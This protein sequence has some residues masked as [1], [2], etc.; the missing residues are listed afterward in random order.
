[1]RIAYLGQMA[2]VA[3][4]NGISKKIR[5]QAAAWLEAGHAVRYFALT[6]SATLWSGLRP[7]EAEVLARGGPLTRTVQSHRLARR[8]RA[9]RPDVIYFRYA[10]HSPGLPALF[11]EIPCV[12][13]INSD[14]EREYPLT[15]TPLKLAYHRLSRARVLRTAT[16][17]LAVTHELA[18][19]FAA[20]GKPTGV[21]ANSVALSEFEPAPPPASP[22]SLVFVGSPGTPWHGL[23]RAGEIAR[24]HPEFTL[25]VIGCTPDD[26]HG[27]TPPPANVRFHGHLPRVRYEPMLRRA[28]AAL[29]TLALFRKQMDEAC[30]L[31]VRE[32][33]ALGLPVIG[34]YEDTD[35]PATADYFL[36]LPNDATSLAP[37]RERI[38]AFLGAWRQRRVPRTAIAHLDTSVKEGARLSLIA[39]F[40]ARR[41]V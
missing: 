12:A 37:E 22:P 30:P 14:D 29:G 1:M 40:A 19:R 35:I 6:P 15:L 27:A 21:I 41:A 36:R 10:H 26:W 2:D 24:F 23:E 16:A 7:L 20:F 9:W 25:D 38:A 39:R 5:T 33:L 3:T 8:I 32:Y 18:R 17:F 34:A 28:T 31:K 4:E 13:E 11:R